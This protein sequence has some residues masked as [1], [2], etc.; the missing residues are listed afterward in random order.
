MRVWGI[1]DVSSLNT[2]Q[3]CDCALD[4]RLALTL[5]VL[6]FWAAAAR[7]NGRVLPS[8]L[9]LVAEAWYVTTGLAIER[10]DGPIVL[11][12]RKPT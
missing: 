7:R 11:G 8:T 3:E 5:L 10:V 4:T 2:Q 9:P 6:L 12:A 1:G